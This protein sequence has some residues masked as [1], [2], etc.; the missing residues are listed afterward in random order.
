M[1][2]DNPRQEENLDRKINEFTQ[3]IKKYQQCGYKNFEIL[4]S[5]LIVTLQMI[6]LLNLMCTFNTNAFFFILALYTSFIVADF[7]NGLVHMFMDNNTH[8]TSIV[9]PFVAAFHLHHVKYN[10]LPRTPVR[11]YF[12]ESGTKFWLLGYLIFLL[13]I[14]STLNLSSFFN[15]GLVAFGIFSS[16]AELSHYWC[17]NATEKNKL[18]IWLQNHHILLSKAHHQA[19]HRQDNTQY[20]FL[21]GATDLLINLIARYCYKGYKN[22]ADKHTNAYMLL[23]TH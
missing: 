17:H 11:V 13:I 6:T 3:A 1:I 2:I 9:G 4:V 15:T 19:H 21:N 22:Y 16:I 7:V 18:I 10:Y 23:S 5:F 14:Q 12:D 20:A 8:Y